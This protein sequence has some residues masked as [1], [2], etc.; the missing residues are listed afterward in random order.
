LRS[1]GG[2]TESTLAYADVRYYGQSH[3]TTVPYAPGDGWTALVERFHRMHEER[4]GFARYGDPVEVV[5]VRAES[6]GRP[7]L[8]WTDLPAVAPTGELDGPNRPIL[9]AT[10]EV[11]ARVVNRGALDE[12]DEIIGPAIVE[13]EVATTY[14]APGDRA[15]VHASGALEVE[16]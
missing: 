10:G 12:G 5:T 2:Q 9:A 3:E 4:N 16:W 8:T 15:V 7:L 13:E 6:V 1:G 14:L 11:T